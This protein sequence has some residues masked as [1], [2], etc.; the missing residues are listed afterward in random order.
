M[1]T[2]VRTPEERVWAARQDRAGARIRR[3]EINLRDETQ[4]L[5]L[6]KCGCTV[7]LTAYT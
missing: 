2:A 6:V 4:F 3:C 7:D 5:D 1:N